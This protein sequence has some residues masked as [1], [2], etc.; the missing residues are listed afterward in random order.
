M[1][2]A[3][4]LYGYDNKRILPGRDEPMARNKTK[5]ERIMKTKKDTWKTVIAKVPEE[6]HRGLKIK[7]AEEGRSVAVIVEKLIREYLVKGG[8]HD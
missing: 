5:G 2:E 8:R 3:T 6:V 7:A 4:V 1:A